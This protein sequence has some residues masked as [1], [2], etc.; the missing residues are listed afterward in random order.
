MD[1]E[2]KL[3]RVGAKLKQPG[4]IESVVWNLD[5]F[6]QVLALEANIKDELAMMAEDSG[7][8]Y[9]Y[10]IGECWT[11]AEFKAYAIEAYVWLL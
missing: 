2:T 11:G 10:D 3:R 6:K 1:A 7:I 4:D 5:D 8:H 9:S